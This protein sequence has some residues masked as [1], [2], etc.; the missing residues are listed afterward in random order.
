MS[1][2]FYVDAGQ[3]RQGPVSAE[4]LVEAFRL[5]QVG[6]NSLAWREG[7]SEWTPL[8]Q[9]RDELGLAAVAPASPP[10]AFVA[11]IAAE[12]AAPAKKGNGCLIAAAVVIGGGVFLLFVV[13]ILAAISV[14]AYQDY[15]GRSKLAVVH[16]EGQAA[17]LAVQEFK[18]NTDRCPRDADELGLPTPSTEGLDALAV[19]SLD[20][21]RCA[22]EITVGTLGNVTSAAGGRL[23][24]ALEEDGTWTC[25]GEG[26]PDK[27]LPPGCR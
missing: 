8:G 7:L 9:F 15:I 13:G 22:V 17:K 14:P 16:M 1:S 19:G 21:G 18:A 26:I 25:S 5:G 6:L 27:L 12:P 11:H 24:M 3:N 23:L 2:W 20:D 4:A 10:P